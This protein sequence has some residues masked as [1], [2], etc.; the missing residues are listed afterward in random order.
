MA[1]TRQMRINALAAAGD[2]SQR[3]AAAARQPAPDLT[4]AARRLLAY[5]DDD[6][7]DT[8]GPTD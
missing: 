6:R 2:A 4:A 1:F 7:T 5:L 3:R 8:D